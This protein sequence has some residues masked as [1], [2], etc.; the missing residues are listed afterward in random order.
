MSDK[1]G[2]IIRIINQCMQ[3]RREKICDKNY[4]EFHRKRKAHIFCNKNIKHQR[5]L[6]DAYGMIIY[7][8]FQSLIFTVKFD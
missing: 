5:N 1:V 7:Q 3:K 4:R 6:S 2:H 8:S